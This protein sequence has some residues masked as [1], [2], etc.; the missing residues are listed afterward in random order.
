[1]EQVKER[2]QTALQTLVTLKK[3]L[4]KLERG[5]AEDDFEEMR[6]AAIQRFEYSI[7]MLWKFLKIYLQDQ[8][9]ITLESTTP[10]SIIRETVNA[11]L[12]SVKDAELLL[13][14]ITSRN[15]TS[16]TYNEDVAERVFKELPAYYEVMHKVLH[17][18]SVTDE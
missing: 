2:Y 10:R 3:T 7:D 16:H 15:E 5:V 17:S 1:M 14:C 6:G 13:D 12:I 9:K 8:L 4:N 11:S 18:I